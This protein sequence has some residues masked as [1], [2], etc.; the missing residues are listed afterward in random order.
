MFTTI[1]K[2]CTPA[3][4]YVFFAAISLLVGFLINFRFVTL[5]VN[6][7]FVLIWAWFLDWM[8][9]K[10]VGVISWA[11]VLLP[12]IFFTASFYISLDAKDASRKEGLS[13]K[14]DKSGAFA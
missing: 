14:T 11:L 7:F 9:R 8:C 1:G 2:Y 6:T 10:G 5:L 4:L 12:F 13:S 3:Q